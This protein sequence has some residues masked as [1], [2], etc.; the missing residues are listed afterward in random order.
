MSRINTRYRRSP[1][2]AAERDTQEQLDREF[3][4]LERAVSF[5]LP[6]NAVS[7]EELDDHV[8][9]ASNPHDTRHAQLPDSGSN[10]HAQLDAHVASSKNPHLVRH[11]QL[12][13]GG[14]NTHAQID[15]HIA[16][17]SIHGGSTG[18]GDLV[19]HVE[20]CYPAVT[21]WGASVGTWD[22]IQESWGFGQ[23]DEGQHAMCAVKGLP[24]ELAALR[25]ADFELS[26][27]APRQD[28]PHNTLH[29]LLPDRG[30]NTHAEIDAHIADTSIHGGGGATDH[31]ALTGLTDDDHSQYHNDARGDARYAIN[32]QA[33]LGNPLQ[34]ADRFMV[35]DD[36]VGAYRRA[37]VDRITQFILGPGIGLATQAEAEAGGEVAGRIFSPLRVKQAIDALPPA[38][39]ASTHVVGGSDELA[40]ADIGAEVAGA[41]AAVQSNLNI[42]T[43]NSGIHA[44]IPAVMP[45]AEAEAGSATTQRTITA[46]VLAAAISALGGG[47]GYAPI[48]G[49]DDTASTGALTINPKNIVARNISVP[50][51]GCL[52]TI[53]GLT[54]EVGSDGNAGAHKVTAK[55]VV[56]G[57]VVVNG[58]TIFQIET[59]TA[60]DLKSGGSGLLLDV[61]NV[62]AGTVGAFVSAELVSSSSVG[63]IFG[64]RL[65]M[66][67][68][69]GVTVP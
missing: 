65:G 26:S 22:V 37:T 46:E 15:A 17:T 33:Q 24:E 60:Q 13:D 45:T 42:H 28:N 11:A 47:G 21:T 6:E 62:T 67:F 51:S 3:A 5:E 41:A 55:L 8:K 56:D 4:K 16:D 69:P 68:L 59:T 64:A 38:P 25:Q 57:T 49:Y 31:G 20:Y 44:P 61:S 18:S 14:S 54:G 32:S 53:A 52:I 43:G 36:S 9:N 12:P 7:R 10:T 35:W 58:A 23:P 50:G 63:S 66:I 34:A 1:I 19:A 27:H 29:A 2:T 40:P 48:V 30:E 39:H